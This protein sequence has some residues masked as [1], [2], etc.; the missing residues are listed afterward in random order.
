MSCLHSP[1]IKLLL[2]AQNCKE[3]EIENVNITDWG[4]AGGATLPFTTP[5]INAWEHL[6][7]RF[8]PFWNIM[9]QTTKIYFTA[10]MREW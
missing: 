10:Y 3:N 7:T 8:F 6:I 5:N 9:G 4:T 1:N 2:F